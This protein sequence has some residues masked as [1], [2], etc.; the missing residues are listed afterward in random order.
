MSEY[1]YDFIYHLKGNITTHP[2]GYK[3]ITD[4]YF[5]LKDFKNKNI[6]IGFKDL[7]WLDA[8]LCALLDAVLFELTT[9]NGH[10]FHA[11]DPEMIEKNFA[12]LMRNGF[13]LDSDSNPIMHDDN[14]SCVRLNKF[15]PNEDVA[16]L[17]YIT[18]DLL[19]HSAFSKNSLNW[20]LTEHFAELFANIE[21]HAR[22]IKPVFA[23]GQYYPK[24]NELKFTIVDL[25]VGFLEPIYSHTK[26][27][28]T[29]YEEAIEWA[30]KGNTTKTSET[31]GIGLKSLYDYCSNNR[32]YFNIISGD[33]Y[34]G[35]S[36]GELGSRKIKPFI[37]T[38]VHLIFNIKNIKV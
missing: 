17:N 18:K 14:K 11:A 31:G 12:V 15:A 34:W 28:I 9:V 2:S 21:T 6:L 5:T 35:N 10:T 26:G 7:V 37:G 38:T 24:Q 3:R 27:E 8:N 29:S 16:F 36:L 30:I 19:G 13:I 4:I 22:T 25:G 20:Q 32:G 1:Q 33:T 23:C